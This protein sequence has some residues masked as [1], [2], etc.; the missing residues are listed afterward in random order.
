MILLR[1]ICVRYAAKD[2]LLSIKIATKQTYTRKKSKLSFVFVSFSQ[3]IILKNYETSP[4]IRFGTADGAQNF[5]ANTQ[6]KSGCILA[7]LLKIVFL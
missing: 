6:P 7:F 5:C 4:F 1:Y 3:S 2:N